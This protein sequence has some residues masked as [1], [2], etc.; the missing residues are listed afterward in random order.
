MK[1]KKWP[2]TKTELT[3]IIN[4]LKKSLKKLERSEKVKL[5]QYLDI[6]KEVFL[7]EKSKSLLKIIQKQNLYPL[8]ADEVI[9]K[10]YKNTRNHNFFK[11]EEVDSVLSEVND[12]FYSLYNISQDKM[13][14]ETFKQMSCYMIKFYRDTNPDKKYYNQKEAY[15]LIKKALKNKED[16]SIFFRKVRKKENPLSFPE[17]FHDF[18]IKL[19][20]GQV[21]KIIKSVFRTMNRPEVDEIIDHILDNCIIFSKENSDT[22]SQFDHY[23]YWPVIIVP[24]IVTFIDLAI[25]VHEVG[26]A[27]HSVLTCRY[28][29]GYQNSFPDVLTCEFVANYFLNKFGQMSCEGIFGLDAKSC[30]KA[31]STVVFSRTYNEAF[32]VSVEDA[33]FNNKLEDY[34]AYDK[35]F[36]KI[37]EKFYPGVRF[38]KKDI[39]WENNSHLLDRFRTHDAF[40]SFVMSCNF[41]NQEKKKPELTELMFFLMQLGDGA[42]TKNLISRFGRTFSV[43]LVRPKRS[44]L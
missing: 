9:K 11:G 39:R 20:K 15:D 22:C 28:C 27:L 14:E 3:K 5:H 13:S 29:K 34:K 1:E 6:H 43:N 38:K 40:L 24:N 21:K 32:W 35:L 10:F 30:Y 23:G 26:H 36:K 44:F 8:E 25:L 18:Q 17:T 41:L 2:L 33:F 37:A 4:R 42:N 31:Y 12:N 19:S 16:G 7:L